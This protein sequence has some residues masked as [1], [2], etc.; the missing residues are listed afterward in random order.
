MTPDRARRL[1]VWAAL[2]IA[3]AS[4]LITLAREQLEQLEGHLAAIEGC[5][6]ELRNDLAVARAAVAEGD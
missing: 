6:F 3:A 1:L 4:L 2:T 5:N